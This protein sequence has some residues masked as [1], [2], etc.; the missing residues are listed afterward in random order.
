MIGVKTDLLHT[1]DKEKM[2][3]HIGPSCLAV[4]EIKTIGNQVQE[5]YVNIPVKFLSLFV[6]SIK[7]FL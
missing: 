5:K 1:W 3:S 4:M 6:P 2:D 7:R